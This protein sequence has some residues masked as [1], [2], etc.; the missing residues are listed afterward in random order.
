MNN[1]PE[2]F[3]NLPAS[4]FPAARLRPN[5]IKKDITNASEES[6]PDSD[7]EPET[8]IDDQQ[9]APDLDN[10]FNR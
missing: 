7:T 3:V 6:Q 5:Y 9:P 8:P 4:R 10:Y 2:N 1:S